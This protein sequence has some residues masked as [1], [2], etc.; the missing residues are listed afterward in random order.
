MK[1]RYEEAN[2]ILAPYRDVSTLEGLQK[3]RD[4]VYKPWSLPYRFRRSS[5]HL[6]RIEVDVLYK[7]RDLI[8]Q[9]D[10]SVDPIDI[11][12]KRFKDYKAKNGDQPFFQ[13]STSNE[14]V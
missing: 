13:E 10:E 1:K 4:R 7:Y 11:A 9:S 3:Y 8:F 12:V 6:W 2:K 14:G 5:K